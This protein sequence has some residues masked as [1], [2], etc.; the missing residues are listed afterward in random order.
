MPL[1]AFAPIV[2]FT[3]LVLALAARGASPAPGDFEVGGPLA[4]LKLPASTQNTGPGPEVELYPGSVE[5]F[6]A[7]FMK[8]LPV[9]SFF[10]RQSQLK[11]WVAP[12]IP[13]GDASKAESYA[14]PIYAVGKQNFGADTGKKLPPVPVIRCAAGGPVFK[15]DLGTLEPG[16]YAVRVIGAVETAKLRPFRAPLFLAM[17]VNDGLKGETSTYRIRCA[18]VDEFYSVAEIY[19]HAPAKR[20]YQAELFVDQG[21]TVELLVHN[22]SLDDCLAGTVRRPIKK[23]MTLTTPEE[24]AALKE[25]FTDERKQALARYKP[26]GPEERLARDAALWKWFPPLN[27]QG[28][29]IHS[30]LPAG[31]TAGVADKTAEQVAAEHGAW[32]LA[33]Q[34]EIGHFDTNLNTMSLDPKTWNAFLVNKKLGL[35]YTID[36][37]WARKPLPDPFP[38]KDDG[39]GLYFPDPSDPAK[40]RIYA[41]IAM[42][43]HRRIRP[44]PNLSGAAKLWIQSGN[45]DLA[46]DAAVDLIRYAYQLPAITDR[47]FLNGVIRIPGGWNNL[48]TACRNRN[49]EELWRSHYQNY[50]EALSVY[51]RLFDYIKRSP[52]LAAS[53]GR[54]VPW[55]K[56]PDDVIQLLDVYLVQTCAKR[57]LR[58]HTH[59]LPMGIAQAAAALGDTSVT[60]PWMEWLFSRA[61]VYPLQ[62]AGAQDLMIVGHDREGPQY[63]GSTFYSQGE[64]ARRMASELDPYLKAGGNP[65]Y[66]LGD[67][68]R[69]PKPL[70]HCEWQLNTIVAGADF[71]RI[72]D[73]CGPDKAPFATTTEGLKDA[74]RFGWRASSDARFAWVLA[75]VFGRKDETDVE[76]KKVEQAASGVKRA[77]WLDLTSR[78]I[79]NWAGI[80]E[81]GREHDDYRM[82]HA[83]Y[84][85]TGVGSGHAHA[86]TMDLQF[87][88]HGMPMTIDGGQRSGYS[89]P[90]DRFSRMH[91]TVEVDGAGNNE[92]GLA[93]YG[94]LSALSDAP[95][96]A[97]LQAAAQPPA[98][99]TIYR[100]QVALIDAEDGPPPAKLPL[101]EQMPRAKLKPALVAPASYLFDVFRVAGGKVHTWCFHGPVSDDFQWNAMNAKPVEHVAE[102]YGT[103]TD[104][105]YLSIFSA[106]GD[107]KQAG[108]SPEAFQATWR[109]TRDD[110]TGS[111]QKMLGANFDAGSPRKFTRVTL[112]GAAGFRAL[113]A[114]TVC[115]QEPIVYRFTCTM[116][117]RKQSG[118]GLQSAFASI[119]EPS[120]GESALV[121]QKT[122]EVADNEA[123]ALR[124]VAIE[125]KTK[126]GRT[127]LCFAD[128]RPEKA[129]RLQA[130]GYK[131]QAAAEFAYLSTDAQGLR[132]ASL[133]GGTLLE[134]SQVR[135]KLG[136]REHVGK[137]TKVDY[138]A[139]TFWLDAPWPAA[140]SG[141]VFEI[142]PPGCPTSFTAASVTPEGVGSRVGVTRSADYYRAPVTN[143]VPEKSRVDGRLGVPV[144]RAGLKGMTVSNGALT[145]FWRLKEVGGGND[146]VV[147]GTLAAAD[148][149]SDPAVRLWEYGVGDAVR[150]PTFAS[151]RRTAPG[152]YELRSNTDMAV[153][154]PAKGMERSADGQKWSPL[155]GKQDA[156]WLE[157]QLK[158]RD[159]AAGPVYLRVAQ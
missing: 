84:V 117:Q 8:Y 22:V 151:L 6:R 98:G 135:L 57:I 26:L 36:D 21:S 111:E 109:A 142:A 52:D 143:V 91:N 158:A 113:K 35:E 64:G 154:F 77:P 120:A 69:Y 48:D 54:F 10:D 41:P 146:F 124:A 104:A 153:T 144:G 90:N 39:Q 127:D 19:F 99:A 130:T 107:S 116:L 122:I 47:D 7:Y 89:K 30:P 59:T 16:L 100:R 138:P 51:D 121:S 149:A 81:A 65:K 152:I 133:T 129:R 119:I 105:K 134:T 110:K 75:N 112:H 74:A 24:I 29:Y 43:V 95:G 40:G 82:R 44:S 1:R 79:E 61:F 17:R 80:L 5:H 106:A 76:W 13:G 86:D 2:A 96:A 103:D 139:K 136:S 50:L 46:R 4:G 71:L 137:I 53:V 49:M 88:A 37:L 114:D 126:G 12:A 97:Y 20:G 68:A 70:A 67:P 66:D 14:S 73:V 92:Y 55:V 62:T 45:P 145:K 23:R 83:A 132:Q 63:I 128:G 156:G 78:H 60:D 3:S 150:M 131:L 102:V 93:S 85:R 18:Y 159:F 108:D 15:L 115:R 33:G 155:A 31:V 32:E 157:A 125:V 87:V 148:F 118:G 27:A 101:E 38:Y 147:E 58:Y 25:A 123:D 34:A 94:W 28:L 140:C 72:G 56:T 11:N 9:R 42:G 141:Q